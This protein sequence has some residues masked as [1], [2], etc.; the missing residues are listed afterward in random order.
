M[1]KIDPDA[2]TV[3]IEADGMVRVDGI[4]LFKIRSFNGVAILQFCDK[5]KWRSSCRKSRFVEVPLNAF[6]E[7]LKLG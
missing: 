5:D 7:R 3:E 2:A 1:T 6:F 4:P